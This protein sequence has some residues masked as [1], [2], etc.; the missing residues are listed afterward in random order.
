MFKWFLNLFLSHPNAKY[1]NNSIFIIDMTG[2]ILQ[3]YVH[4]LHTDLLDISY[5]HQLLLGGNTAHCNGY[6]YSSIAFFL[7]LFV[8]D[9]N[10]KDLNISIFMTVQIH[11]FYVHILHMDISYEH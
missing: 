1:L 5:E 4:L 6:L 8:S 9:P 11:Q 2:G 3:F 7:H 10:A